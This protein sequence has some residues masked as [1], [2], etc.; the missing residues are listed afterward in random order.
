MEKRLKR[1]LY[2]SQHRGMKETDLMVGGFAEAC[3]K[4][5]NTEEL[6]QFEALMDVPDGDL[7]NWILGKSEPQPPHDTALITRIR[8]FN[9]GVKKG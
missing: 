7:L 8:A 6:D 2:Q 9:D 3:I 1:L 5:L 4:D